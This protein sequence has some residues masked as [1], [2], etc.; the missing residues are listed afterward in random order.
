M[1]EVFLR[2]SHLGEDIFD[3]LDDQNL[4]R[5]RKVSRTWNSFIED[6]KYTWIRIIKKHYEKSN[7][8][9]RK[10]PGTWKKLFEK[11]NVEDVRN[12]A[13]RILFEEIFYLIKKEK[14]K[15]RSRGQ[16]TFN[17]NNGSTIFHYACIHGRFKIVEMLMQKSGQLKLNLNAKNG[18]YGQTAFHLVC[19]NGHS[20][21]AKMFLEKATDI[22]LDVNARGKN[23]MTAFHGACKNGQMKIA[24]L[25]IKKSS[26]LNIDLNALGKL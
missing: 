1:E 26:E 11:I 20:M 10:C 16:L 3:S 13:K 19:I 4:K 9:N 23:G 24:D 17:F 18:Y 22:N 8:K 5:C 25:L 12:Y 21:I 2:F 7:Q 14:E 15:N 6:Q